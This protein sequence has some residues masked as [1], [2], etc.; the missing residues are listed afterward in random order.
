MFFL[1]S[2]DSYP[3]E[4][5]H[6]QR[7]LEKSLH[8]IFSSPNNEENLE[9]L[10]TNLTNYIPLICALDQYYEFI[11]LLLSYT[12]T[13]FDLALYIL[14]YVTSITDD[15]SEDFGQIEINSDKTSSA[16]IVYIWLKKYWLSRYFGHALFSS[17]FDSI[18][19]L[20]TI[21]NSFNEKDEFLNDINIFNQD[22]IQKKY[23]DIEYLTKTIYLLG[24][25][26]SLSLEETKQTI[27]AL[28]IYL[29]HLS[30]GSLVHVLLWLIA[31]YQIAN[32]DERLWIQNTIHT[33]GNSFQ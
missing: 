14:C 22:N 13:H 27:S 7:S 12:Q 16:F 28:I 32:D 29:T 23:L 6:L 2:L 20:P 10:I 1:L 9:N 8:K 26:P 17:S 5:L 21:N 31:N 4:I 19:L 18:D 11:R 33:M 30:Y 15:K 24:E 3:Y 25:L